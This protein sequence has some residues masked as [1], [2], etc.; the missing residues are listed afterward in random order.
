MQALAIA[1]DLTGALEVGAIL[2]GLGVPSLVTLDI[3]HAPVDGVLVI[4]TE[5]RHTAPD[6]ARELHRRLA[7]RWR[8]PIFKK[9][10]STLRGNIGAEFSGLIEATGRPLVYVPAYPKVGRTVVDGVLYVEG[11]PIAETAFARD[12]RNPV[13]E[14]SVIRMVERG[15]PYPVDVRDASTDDDLAAIAATLEPGA[16]VA[17]PAG[18]TSHWA[19]AMTRGAPPPL[20]TV[21][22]F[23]L[24]CGSL[25][26]R[27]R[28]QASEAER[29]GWDV[30]ST[31]AFQEG[32][33]T[34][35]ARELAE[36]ALARMPVDALVIFGGDTAYAVLSKLGCVDLEPLG[37]ILPG[38]PV[39][40]A[41][42]LTLVTKA[43]GFGPPDLAARIREKLKKT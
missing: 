43:G 12:P 6:A 36:R 24:L 32:G 21:G 31:G 2:A 13:R 22:S 8:G 33:E 10:D 29:S 4:D 39:S 37:E 42:G 41:G 25:H 28:E 1:D 26:P 38:V 9:T 15:C 11:V 30:L 3:N 7:A 40:R 16:L 23:L 34:R 14:S 18:F 17:S 20:P 35:A 5:T 19:R 27:S